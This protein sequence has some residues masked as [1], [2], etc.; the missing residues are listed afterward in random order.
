MKNFRNI[1]LVTPVALAVAG[2]SW[3]GPHGT[4]EEKSA[5]RTAASH[6]DR[7]GMEYAIFSGAHLNR[8]FDRVRQ[9]LDDA[10]WQSSMSHGQKV[11][12]QQSSAFFR[13]VWQLCGL[14]R[15]QT[16]GFSSKTLSENPYGENF[17]HSKIFLAIPPG[18]DGFLNTF[19][20]GNELEVKECFGDLPQETTL[21]IGASI[22][23]DA[24]FQAF[25]SAGVW[26]E[27][28]ALALADTFPLEEL[29]QLKGVWQ[30]AVL[31]KDF[32]HIRL[33]LPAEA[34]KLNGMI[35]KL[36]PA[37][38]VIPGKSRLVIYSSPAARKIFQ[39]DALKMR[40]RGDFEML[41]DCMPDNGFAYVFKSQS[42]ADQRHGLDDFSVAAR[43]SD[44]LL[45]LT[46]SDE[47]VL[48]FIV[49]ALFLLDD[50]NS[51][52]NEEPVK[53]DVTAPVKPAAAQVNTADD[54]FARLAA[55][56]KNWSATPGFEGLRASFRN[57]LPAILSQD[58]NRAPDAG[59]CMLIYFGKSPLASHPL[60]ISRPRPDADSFRVL[61]ND[62]KI[63][64][65]QLTNASSCRRIISFLHTIHRWDEADFQRLIA[66]A[67]KFDH[68]KIK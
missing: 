24:I 36:F 67:D 34:E 51:E 25:K 3:W 53:P 63:E 29:R 44:G 22:D 59:N 47:G 32:Q 9:D 8:T 6:L 55:C 27:N 28:T 48:N 43:N 37:A 21:A 38:E 23:P 56:R 30:C 39:R 64:T 58:L 26:G 46:N 13:M 20:G 50:F 57:E 12:A 17:K 2:C 31:D 40:D 18:S 54:A 14:E 45:I 62:G 61:Y 5:F 10:V 15:L 42:L 68:K 1:L 66:L 11:E 65:Y 49:E 60:A 19:F 52:E 35:K 41:T 7:D 16:A 33:I 4:P